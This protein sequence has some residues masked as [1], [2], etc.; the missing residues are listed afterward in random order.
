MKAG[1][2]ILVVIVAIAATIW[3]RKDYLGW[4]SL[5]KGGLPS[6]LR[7]W[8]V[9]TRFRM[10]KRDPIE[11]GSYAA[12]DDEPDNISYLDDL[13]RRNGPR[14]A[15]APWPIP[16]RQLSQ[17]VGS[18]I[19]QQL[20]ALFNQAVARHADT[21]H[22]KL[23]FFEKHCPAVT[24]LNPG[25]G[26]V[27]A[28]FG[29]GETAHIHPGDGSMHMIFSPRDAKKVL[30]ASWGERHP[31]SGVLPELPSTYVYIYPPRDEYELAVVGQLLDAAIAHMA[32]TGLVKKPK[33]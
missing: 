11:T 18:G 32:A 7:G 33:E 13:P 22:F 25:C 24:L 9:T 23:S 31:M 8:L 15:I 21:V 27:H 19:R 20:D 6:N 3:A 29:E 4:I 1:L 28:R 10:R 5:G 2:L 26:H 16:H 17:F 12:D 30:D 14:P